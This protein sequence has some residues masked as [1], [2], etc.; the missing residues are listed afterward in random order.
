MR[1]EFEPY[2]LIQL[3]AEH[4]EMLFKIF[5]LDSLPLATGE[6]RAVFRCFYF[7]STIVGSLAIDKIDKGSC[8]PTWSQGD[9]DESSVRGSGPSWLDVLGGVIHVG[10][11]DGQY[12]IWIIW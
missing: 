2:H 10:L 4:V 7:P 9:L 8:S 6:H 3:G 12:I 5:E 11:S 1:A